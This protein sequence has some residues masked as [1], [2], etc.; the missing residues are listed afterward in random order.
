MHSQTQCP[1]YQMR[2]LTIICLIL[3]FTSCDNSFEK[4]KVENEKLSL[5]NDSLSEVINNFELIPYLTNVGFATTLNDTFSTKLL[6]I[7]N[8]G[9]FVDSI[10]VK[11][12]SKGRS[13]KMTELLE[14]DNVTIINFTSD[15]L[16]NLN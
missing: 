7:Q 9:I 14:S 1:I 3:L 4:L 11:G 10:I 12:M 2:K 8:D 16:G 13:R 5:I 6:L 15:S